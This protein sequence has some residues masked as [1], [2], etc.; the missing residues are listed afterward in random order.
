MGAVLRLGQLQLC[1]PGCGQVERVQHVPAV[2]RDGI[3]SYGGC[4]W[5]VGAVGGYSAYGYSAHSGTSVSSVAGALAPS[6]LERRTGGLVAAGAFFAALVGVGILIARVATRTGPPGGSQLPNVGAA[7]WMIPALAGLPLLLI[8]A[9]LLE[10]VRAN[11]RIRGGRPAASHV[12]R[13]G[14]Y[15]HRCG[16]V[17]FPGGTPLEVPKD[18]LLPLPVFQSIVWTAGRF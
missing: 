10:R 15:C 5:S 2:Y 13:H 3:A 17:F 12:W 14:W 16:G 6:P 18:E 4:A 7:A 9:L 11:G 1:C 8:A